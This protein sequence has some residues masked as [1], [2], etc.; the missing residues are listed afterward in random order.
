MLK[1]IRSSTIF[2]EDDWTDAMEDITT[3]IMNIKE[4]FYWDDTGIKV[5]RRVT[6]SSG[7]VTNPFYVHIDSTRMGFHSVEYENGVIKN[8]VE[9]VHIGNNSATVQNATFQGE[10]DTTF[11][12]NA[13]FNKQVTIRGTSDFIWK[14]ESNGSLSLAIGGI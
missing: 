7:N 6:D 5:M 14:I 13:V 12:N 11:E 4:S 8:D 9:V 1:A 10:N 3:T 2:S